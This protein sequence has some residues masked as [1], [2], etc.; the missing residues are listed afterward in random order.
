MTFVSS[1]RMTS[2]SSSSFPPSSS[3]RSGGQRVLS[4]GNP[5][6]LGELTHHQI[7]REN[8]WRWRISPLGGRALTAATRAPT[9]RKEPRT[10]GPGLRGRKSLNSFDPAMDPGTATAP[11]G[12]ERHCRER[13]GPPA[14][15]GL[16]NRGAIRASGL[17]TEREH[18]GTQAVSRRAGSPREARSEGRGGAAFSF[19]SDRRRISPPQ[20][21]S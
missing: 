20:S 13:R 14:S 15:D 1:S 10:V 4:P 6:V 17:C 5:A 9:R 19:P 18:G 3:R 12:P 11:G 16:G 7:I 8:G 2:A 21:G